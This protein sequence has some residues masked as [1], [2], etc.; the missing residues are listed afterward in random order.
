MGFKLNDRVFCKL[1]K[2]YGYVYYIPSKALILKR[3]L[4]Y[5]IYVDFDPEFEDEDFVRQYTK[6]GRLPLEH[7]SSLIK[8][9]LKEKIQKILKI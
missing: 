9:D 1:H 3:D 8:I 4:K 5:I 7:E 2:R 6:D